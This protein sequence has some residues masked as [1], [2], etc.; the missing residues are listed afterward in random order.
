MIIIET[1]KRVPII[2]CLLNDCSVPG[3]GP[4]IEMFRGGN[5]SFLFQRVL[6]LGGGGKGRQRQVI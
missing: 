6:D 5:L 2:A 3:R 1:M 4:D